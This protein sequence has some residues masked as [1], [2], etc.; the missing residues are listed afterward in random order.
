MLA[1][2]AKS[3]E[4]IDREKL[5]KRL[6]LSSDH[7]LPDQLVEKGWLHK[8]DSAARLVGD[9]T[10]QMV[11]LLL[12]GDQLREENSGSKMY[13]EAKSGSV[14]SG[15]GGVRF[16]ERAVLFLFGDAFGAGRIGKKG[17]SGI[18]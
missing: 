13:T 15:R 17:V 7:P 5:L 4:G 14:P 8:L 2:V 18:L 1:E 10:L 11:R 12:T 16:G 3:G 9:A 6:G